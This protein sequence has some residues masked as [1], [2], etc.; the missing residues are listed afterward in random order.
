M[1]G[2]YPEY[3]DD[4]R[5]S[6]SIDFA[7][8]LLL[9]KRR[10][11]GHYR[12]PNPAL[13]PDEAF[14]LLLEL[15]DRSIFEELDDDLCDIENEL[16]DAK[17]AV[18]AHQGIVNKN[19]KGKR[20]KSVSAA[21]TQEA[22]SLQQKVDDCKQKRVECKN[23]SA[24]ATRYLRQIC[25]A[26]ANKV[27]PI[28]RE[29]TQATLTHGG[30]QYVT[31]TSLESWIDKTFPK[32]F[33]EE[34]ERGASP[35]IEELY[36]PAEDQ[37]N[38]KGQLT[39]KGLDSL[40]LSFGILMNLYTELANEASV[41]LESQPNQ[42]EKELKATAPNTMIARDCLH[43]DGSLNFSTFSKFMQWRATKYGRH[44]PIHGQGWERIKDRLEASEKMQ[45]TKLGDLIP[46]T[47]F[48]EIT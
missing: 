19:T 13:A 26:L 25:D 18:A 32:G 3:F 6:C 9:G 27:D 45:H 8:G 48:L 30:G 31:L 43:K 38:E 1:S 7:V 34:L 36:D 44:S 28:L 29:D 17:D 20:S 14:E 23:A 37:R 35:V 24:L 21:L 15:L 39:K 4:R 42:T 5:T 33:R 41:A 11:D 40:Y 16:E 2:H 10:F 22:Q 46:I 12:N 47:T